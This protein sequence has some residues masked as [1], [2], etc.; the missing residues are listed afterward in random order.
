MRAACRFP[1]DVPRESQNPRRA[2]SA[3]RGFVLGEAWGLLG[4]SLHREPA[5]GD[6]P[7]TGN[8]KRNFSTSHILRLT[9]H[10]PFL[11][12]IPCGASDSATVPHCAAA[13]IRPPAA[14]CCNRFIFKDLHTLT[15]IQ[16]SM[17]PE[18]PGLR[19]ALLWSPLAASPVRQV[20]NIK[21]C[22]I[23]IHCCSDRFV[24]LRSTLGGLLTP[25][26]ISTIQ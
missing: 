18:A 20:K 10:P 8:R 22:C 9:N 13:V 14:E 1:T 3:R 4:L 25:P 26:S 23:A 5:T 24:L 2:I 6:L 19:R 12:S 11:A 7:I 17:L 21:T 15:L 16:G